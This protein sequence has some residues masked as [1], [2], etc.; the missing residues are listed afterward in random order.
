MF[1]YFVRVFRIGER[2]T[3]VTEMS[4]LLNNVDEGKPIANLY[5]QIESGG[6]GE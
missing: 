1:S 3:N 5:T 6:E 2:V 4:S